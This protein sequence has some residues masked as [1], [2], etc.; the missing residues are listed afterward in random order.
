MSI[1]SYRGVSG[2]IVIPG[3]GAVPGVFSSWTIKRREDSGTGNPSWS[4]HAVLSYQNDTMLKNEALPKRFICELS[5]TQ[6]FEL[7][8]YESLKLEGAT[9][10]VEG[11]IQCPQK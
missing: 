9:L 1:R 8:G 11:V 10:I 6:K 3:V 7:C 4:L 2:R 5:K